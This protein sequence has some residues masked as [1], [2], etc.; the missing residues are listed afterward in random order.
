MSGSLRSCAAMQ[1]E[2]QTGNKRARR[3]FAGACSVL[4]FPLAWQRTDRGYQTEGFSVCSAQ[5]KA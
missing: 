2:V 3:L 1:I 5:R 4:F